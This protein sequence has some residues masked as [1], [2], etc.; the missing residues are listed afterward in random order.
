MKCRNHTIVDNNLCLATLHF[1]HVQIHHACKTTVFVMPTSFLQCQGSLV[2]W[3][4]AIVLSLWSPDDQAS[5]KQQPDE[6]ASVY[7]NASDTIRQVTPLHSMMR[8][9]GTA[10]LQTRTAYPKAA[11]QMTQLISTATNSGHW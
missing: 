5:L 11:M 7:T 3:M 8:H 2:H 10:M 4:V 6:V 1:Y 9:V